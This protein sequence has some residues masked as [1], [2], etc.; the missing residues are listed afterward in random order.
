VKRRGSVRFRI[1]AVATVVVGATLGLGSWALVASVDKRLSDHVEKEQQ[2][3]LE[4]VRMLL[5]TG[6]PPSPGMLADVAGP[7]SVVAVIGE[8]GR[9]IA[10]T[11][12]SLHTSLGVSASGP[13]PAPAEGLGPVG[14]GAGPNSFE[15][16][17]VTDISGTVGGGAQG[18]DILYV[19]GL[20]SDYSIRTAEVD[21]PAGTVTVLTANSLADIQRSVS[22]LRGY[23]TGGIP[24]LAVLAGLAT[25]WL[26]GRA[27][28]PVDAMCAE[29][30]EITARTITRRVPEPA[31]GDE[32]QHL[33]RTMNAMLGRLEEGQVRQRRFVS[34]ASHE[35]RS[36]VAVART[37]L[38]VALAHPEVTD[39]PA[40][41]STVLHE[42]GR[43]DRLV[44]DLLD[45]ARL[46]EDGRPWEEV[47]LEE[48]VLDEAGRFPVIGA[49]GVSAGRVVGDRRLLARLV[50]NLCDNAV[51]HARS[52]VTVS[53]AGDEQTVTLL[54][55]DDGAGIPAADRERVFERFTR[56][57]EGRARDGGGAG[58][59][60]AMVR[61]IAEQHGGRV[62]AE[63]SRTGGA[64]FVVE[65]PAAP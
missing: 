37:N 60:L 23:L 31:T 58:L 15:Q 30:D 17:V 1:A 8:D 39:W 49:Q 64:R 52:G 24:I 5:S 50:R 47:D 57:E 14:A 35:L 38:E 42:T 46:D 43:L 56:L 13:D 59:G 44:A 2:A 19:A 3:Q 51:R 48:V 27:L 28:R 32:I 41:A 21:T 26:V 4:R 11:N 7:G 18:P 36:P 63:A 45:L 55:E 34:D 22:T 6:T 29:V 65:L 12:P 10:V 9:T 61:R 25:W 62:K 33:A 53:L 20:P 16:K 40:V 54:V